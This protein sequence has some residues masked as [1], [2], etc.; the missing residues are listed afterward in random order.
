MIIDKKKIKDSLVS[1]TLSF[2]FSTVL[3]VY[4][5]KLPY[6]IT[7][8]KNIV[9]EY[10]G[11][12]FSS[13]VPLDMFFI[14]LYFIGALV[15]IHLLKVKSFNSK[16]LVVTLTTA[17]TTGLFCYYFNSIPQS[18]A[19]FSRWFNTV[20]YKSVLYDV[21]LLGF[22]FYIYELLLNFQ[23]EKTIV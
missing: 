5:L 6:I 19:F 13:F 21:L 11:E 18:E 22:N 4:L 14:A 10:Y 1:F 12:N 7:G 20:K 8:S 15:I 16:L 2:G 17:I 23:K 3:M 9:N